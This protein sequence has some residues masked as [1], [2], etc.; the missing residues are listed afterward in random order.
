MIECMFISV[1]YGI[2]VLLLIPSWAL[3][4]ATNEVHDCD[5]TVKAVGEQWRWLY[6]I[7]NYPM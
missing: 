7:H 5:C 3:I 2:V 1:P 6:E 4:Y